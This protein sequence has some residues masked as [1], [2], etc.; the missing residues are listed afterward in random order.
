M[1]SLVKLLVVCA[2]IFT[3]CETKSTDLFDTLTGIQVKAKKVKETKTDLKVVR[4]CLIVDVDRCPFEDKQP[5]AN[6]WWSE[7]EKDYF[8]PTTYFS[9][10]NN[11]QLTFT[12]YEDGTAN[13]KGSTSMGTCI[14][15]VNVWLKD[16]KNWA[17]W[18]AAGGEHKK[19]GC[20]GDASNS[21]GMNFYLIDSERS[22]LTA[23]GGDCIAE[24]TFG[25]EQRPD[26]TNTPNFGAHLG[27]G[28]ANY[29]SDLEALGM[30]TW[31]WITNKATGE[32]L[33]IMDFNFKLECEKEEAGCETAFARNDNGDNCFIDNGFNRWGWT[34]GPILEGDY[35]YEIYAAAG[36]CDI[37][38][39]E[40]VGTVDVSY[41]GGDVEVTYNID[42]SYDVEE[43]HTYAGTDMFPAKNSN[44]TVAP[45]QY[46]IE[47]DLSGEIFVIAHAVVCK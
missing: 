5:T 12:E 35:Q 20:T 2:L 33:W 47:S 14:V 7:N 23:N 10:S 29:D 32:R 8:N 6:F 17:D 16:K 42:P 37:N 1:K 13:I 40:L 18:S 30:S 3:S 11:H 25:V 27:I 24:G 43:T 19:E 15:E 36:Q 39:G 34:L 46:S 22:S 26:P 4:E 41:H 28:G 45:G 44:F 38:K 21:E 31:G 9:S